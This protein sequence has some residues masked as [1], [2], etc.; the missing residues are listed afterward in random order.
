M[1]KCIFLL[2]FAVFLFV[3]CSN[4]LD[5]KKEITGASNT[6]DK[7]NVPVP[8]DTNADFNPLNQPDAAEAYQAEELARQ[9][10]SDLSSLFKEMEDDEGCGDFFS[11]DFESLVEDFREALEID[12]MNI[13]A[14]LGYSVT[15]ILALNTSEAIKKLADSLSVYYGGE[16]CVTA[17]SAGKRMLESGLRKQADA[18]S[19]AS[20]PLF[21]TISHIQ[22]ITASE[23]IPVLNNI[24]AALN[25]ASLSADA[26]VFT[27]ENDTVEVDKG[28]IYVL[29][30][31]MRLI[32]AGFSSFCMYDMDLFSRGSDNYEWLDE[33]E[34]L[35]AA[36][37]GYGREIFLSGDT[38]YYYLKDT[39]GYREY[40]GQDCYTQYYCDGY[41]CGYYH[42]YCSYNYNSLSF[43][44][45][46]YL[47]EIL[48]YNVEERESFLTLREG[49][50]STV[51]SDLEGALSNLKDA[52]GSIRAETDLQGNDIIKKIDVIRW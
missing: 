44:R 36:E 6:K 14:N 5:D 15:S 35:T 40:L 10:Y 13:T 21:I 43:Q 31:G 26:A 3:F 24:I 17:L 4:P 46:S 20:W 37:Y 52:L 34:D 49:V 1:K 27:E 8:V 2:C 42:S 48:K 33:Y 29:L 41:S 47:A 16:S 51:F 28:E 30:A 39:V 50:F 11:E 23:I 9:S 22:N 18:V 45:A 7:S 32:R 25:R 19:A 38:L 12:P